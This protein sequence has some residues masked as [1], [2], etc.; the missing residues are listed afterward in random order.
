MGNAYVDIVHTHA[1]IDIV[2]VY[3][4]VYVDVVHTHAH[5]DI[6]SVDVLAYVDVAHMHVRSMYHPAI[7]SAVPVPL[8]CLL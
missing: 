6:V 4:L 1:R 7:A 8:L 3:V 5:I 2:S